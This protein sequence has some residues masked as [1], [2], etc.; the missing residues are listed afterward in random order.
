MREMIQDL[1]DE[2]REMRTLIE[3]GRIPA[4]PVEVR[5]FN[6]QEAAAAL[7]YSVSTLDRLVKRGLLHPNRASRRVVF[8]PEELQRFRRECSATIDVA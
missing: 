3:R 5:Q 8:S 2:V 4:P 1:T 7:G 6:R